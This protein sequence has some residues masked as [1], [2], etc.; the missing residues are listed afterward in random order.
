MRL[1]VLL[2]IAFSLLGRYLAERWHVMLAVVV[3]SAL[4]GAGVAAL[5]GGGAVAGA[6]W[7]GGI[8]TVAA[9]VCGIISV[10]SVLR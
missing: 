8:A 4:A 3:V 1:V 7:A 6:L 10:A 2:L 5:A 9:L